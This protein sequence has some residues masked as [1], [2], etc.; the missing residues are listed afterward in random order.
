[1]DKGLVPAGARGDPVGGEHQ[2]AAR[3]QR[4][5]VQ[6]HHRDLGQAQLARRQGAPVARDQDPITP[7]QDR[8]CPAEFDHRGSALGHLGVGVGA[9]VADVGGEPLHRPLLDALGQP[10]LG[11][12]ATS[13][14]G[15]SFLDR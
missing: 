12:S 3:G 4:E 8:V 1:M 6:D 11:H 5:V 15:R 9:G 10:V 13:P 2:G 14:A 7:G